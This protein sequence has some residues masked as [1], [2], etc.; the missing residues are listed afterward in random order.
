[1]KKAVKVINVSTS[2]NFK[3]FRTY[4]IDL[5]MIPDS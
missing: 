1:M 3:F 5:H 4:E 2:F